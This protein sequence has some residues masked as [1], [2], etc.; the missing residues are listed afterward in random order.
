MNSLILIFY[1]HFCCN[2]RFAAATGLVSRARPSDPPRTGVWRPSSWRLYPSWERDKHRRHKVR[3]YTKAN[4]MKGSQ[5]RDP[6]RLGGG[7]IMNTSLTFGLS[8][9]R[10]VSFAGT[11]REG[12][13]GLL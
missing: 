2:R 5:I 13:G 8:P 9:L 11:A 7:S 1:E 3:S 4:P 12:S 6:F 10:R